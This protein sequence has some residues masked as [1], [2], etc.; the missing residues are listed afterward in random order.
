MNRYLYIHHDENEYSVINFEQSE[1]TIEY[2][3]N[4]LEVGET[5]TFEPYD[6]IPFSATLLEFQDQTELLNWLIREEFS[7]DYDERKHKD[8][9][10]L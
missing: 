5:Q 2:L 4:N 9:I 8:L 6:D 10:K 7:F 1:Y 3:I